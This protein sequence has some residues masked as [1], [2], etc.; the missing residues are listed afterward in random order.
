MTE[1]QRYAR[2]I[3]A[4]YQPEELAKMYGR[5]RGMTVGEM[6]AQRIQVGPEE[7]F[8]TGKQPTWLAQYTTA[9]STYIG[10]GPDQAVRAER[11]QGA[12]EAVGAF[13]VYG[14]Q[15]LEQRLTQAKT[16]LGRPLTSAEEAQRLLQYGGQLGKLTETGWAQPYMAARELQDRQRA[17]GMPV[18]PMQP[19]PWFEAQ[20]I[21]P[22]Q[23]AAFTRQTQEA[24]IPTTMIEQWRQQSISMFGTPPTYGANITPIQIQQGMTQTAFGGQL[25]QQ[26]MMGGIGGEF[27]TPG[28][29]AEIAEKI[30][31]AF[32]EMPA[33]LYRGF[34]D[35]MSMNPLQ[36]AGQ[37][38]QNPQIG[39]LLGQRGALPGRGGHRGPN[40]GMTDVN[41]GLTGMTWEQPHLPQQVSAMMAQGIPQARQLQRRL[42]VAGQ[43]WGEDYASRTDIRSLV[44]AMISGRQFGAQ[45]CSGTFRKLPGIYALTR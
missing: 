9:I 38:M 12:M 36:M 17:V 15:G 33:H 18:T 23:Q 3:Q 28:M 45:A 16:E 19:L 2:Q 27:A 11:I 10:E 34:R 40:T 24:A 42:N 4:G 29:S 32:E 39:A 5:L 22:T 6:G 1:G 20:P 13:G 44:G 37:M 30:G 31:K 41:G 7:Y 25:A 35:L 8:G 43:I 21:S 26:L 14:R